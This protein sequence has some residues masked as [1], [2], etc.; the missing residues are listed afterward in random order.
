M[1][2]TAD[3]IIIGGGV[4]GTSIA[5]HLAKQGSG[6][7]LLVERRAICNGTTAHSGAIVRQHYSHDF[8]V[9]MAKESLHLFQH[10]NDLVGGDCGFIQTGVLIFADQEGEKALQANV[11]LQQAQGVNVE[12]LTP[13]DVH[14]RCP[15]YSGNDIS[16][17]CYEPDAGVADP[18]ATTHCFARR[19]RDYGAT[20]LEGAAVQ[21]ILIEKGRV[22]GVE[23][24][25]GRFLA[26]SIVLAANVWSV[27]LAHQISISLPITATRHPMLALR[28]PDDMGGRYK[29]H[30]V[31]LDMSR[32]LYLRPDPGGVT[33]VGSCS[34]VHTPSDPDH[35]QQTLTREEI[36][37][38][39]HKAPEIMPAL[40]R[41]AMRGG[42]AGLYD[43][44]PDY[45]PI[46]SALPDY[47][48]LYCAAGFSGHG[49]KLS[50]IVGQW[51]AALVRGD[52]LPADLLH[53]DIQRFQQGRTIRP[54]YASSGVLG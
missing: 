21:R 5:Y 34:D 51:M 2:Q 11:A 24:T 23:T 9:R 18:M 45:H 48:G 19:A 27:A 13:A 42:W 28:Q 36:S 17:A 25:Q 26:P 35:Y 32:S 30:A 40:A 43:D 29:A 33:L 22:I 1:T 41:A 49:F 20:I 52:T 15:E 6:R 46:L 7:V 50:P 39:A 14:A 38:F 54:Q 44:T 4:I 12:V 3:C 16:L 53:F 31:C 47:E 8:T 10:F 37:F